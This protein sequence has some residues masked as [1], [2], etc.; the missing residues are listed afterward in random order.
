[1][2][3]GGRIERILGGFAE[4]RQGLTTVERIHVKLLDM[5]ECLR[6]RGFVCH[7]ILA[8]RIAFKLGDVEDAIPTD[9][10]FAI[11][12]RIDWDCLRSV[13]R[14][15]NGFRAAWISVAIFRVG[16]NLDGSAARGRGIA[17]GCERGD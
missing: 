15:G 1:M 2:R 11:D 10:C 12:R 3:A 4:F 9:W 5:A 17:R 6:D 7:R 13:R 14:V 8:F 16:R